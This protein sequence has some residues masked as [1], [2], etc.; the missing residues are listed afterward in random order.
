MSDV[1]GS[2]QAEYAV[3]GVKNRMNLLVGRLLVVL[4]PL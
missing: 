4:G 2:V 3:S 1:L